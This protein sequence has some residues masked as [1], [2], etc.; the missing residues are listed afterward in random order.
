[1]TDPGAPGRG[2]H[3]SS[4][5]ITGGFSDPTGPRESDL[6]NRLARR[7]DVDLGRHAHRSSVM[8]ADSTGPL[9]GRPLDVAPLPGDTGL[10]AARARHAADDPHEGSVSDP[11]LPG[12]DWPD[13]GY[14]P[15]GRHPSAPLPPRPAGV[16]DK[17]NRHADDGFDEEAPTVAHRLGD[18]PPLPPA[19]AHGTA[20][21][22]DEPPT[23]SHPQDW[24]DATGG[25][26]VIGEHV[27][28]R[29][30]RRRRRSERPA[31]DPYGHHDDALEHTDVH[32]TEDEL[33]LHASDRRAGRRRRRRPLGTA[34]VLI[35]LVAVVAGVIFGGKTLLGVLNP[36]SEDFSGQGSGSVDIK[37]QEGDTLSDIATTLVDAGVIASTDP[38]VE[39]AEANAAS[40]G[41]QPGTY[42]LH[43]KMSGQAALDLLLDPE[44]RML[45]KVTLPE[46]LTVEE[47]LQRLSEETGAPI[48]ELKAAAKK[49][50]ALGVPE[51]AGDELEGYLFPATYDFEPGTTPADMLKQMVAQFDAVSDELGLAERAKS[52]GLTP[53]QVVTVAS[54]VE[55][56]TRLDEERADVAQVIYNRLREDT[57]LGIDATLAYGLGKNGNELTVKDLETD[58]PYNTRTRTGLPPTP[59]SAPGKASLEAALHP[60]KGD[61]LYYV[62]KSEEGAHF[63]TGDYDEFVEA[64]ARCA[65]AGLGCGG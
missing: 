28:E 56:E 5:G 4:G 46:G 20:E 32:A 63:F 61:L 34:L 65:A 47:V 12:V 33:T 51:F 37:V 16:W 57:P 40:T 49:P 3:Y 52:I 35:L 29:R 53:E 15:E 30:G 18:G 60:T 36:S 42:T 38:F 55:A 8:D 27:D 6:G 41:I 62:L 1:M 21:H 17:L 54:M 39:A 9:I 45:S 10:Y 43:S 11:D 44:A 48:E 2:R 58:S 7:Y 14:V 24:Q 50:R 22:H 31:A 13:D 25:L 59:I 64:R 19:D 26:E 23:E